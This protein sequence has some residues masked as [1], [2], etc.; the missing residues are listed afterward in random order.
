MLNKKKLKIGFFTP[1]FVPAWRF[2]GPVNTAYELGKE[3]IQRGHQVNIYCTDVSNWE[4]KRVTKKRDI[5]QGMKVYYFRNINNKL[6]SKY[7]LFLPFEMRK[8]IHSEIEKLDIIHIQD[9]YT[10][11]T[12]WIHNSIKN[13][14]KP[15][16]MTPFGG[17]T[18]LVQDKYYLFRKLINKL[19]IKQLK[20][21]DLVFAQTVEE[22]EIL[23]KYGLSNVEILENGIN[24][25]QFQN[26]PPKNIFRKKYNFSND[27]LIIL[28]L[29]RINQIKGLKYLIEAFSYLNNKKNIKLVIIGPDDNYLDKLLNLIKKSRLKSIV[30]ILGFVPKH[31]KIEALAGSDIFCLPSN[32]DCCPNSMLEAL[33]SGLPVITTNTNGLAY[34]LEEQAGIIIPPKNPERLKDA[35]IYLIENPGK[36]VEYGKAGRD[37]VLKELNWK[38]ITDYLEKFYYSYLKTKNFKSR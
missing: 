24:H 30:K 6:A 28:Y 31:E 16:F 15:L 36:R 4:N 23:E 3:L 10:I 8:Y 17:L 25:K 14:R 37:K 19:V 29:G 34:L 33:A 27:D 35:L 5:I 26:L 38:K 20:Y 18:P 7:K 9:V 21:A 32:Y 11:I 13:K 1:N 22:K 2:G 12:F